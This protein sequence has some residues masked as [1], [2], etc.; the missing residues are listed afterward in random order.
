M[1]DSDAFMC[2]YVWSNNLKDIILLMYHHLVAT[3][4]VSIYSAVQ[5]ILFLWVLFLWLQMLSNYKGSFY[6]EFGIIV[7]GDL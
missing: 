2:F 3:W 5:N 4:H 6:C 1:M 7:L